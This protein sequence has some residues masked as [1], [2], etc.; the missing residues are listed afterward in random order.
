MRIIL[1]FVLILFSAC[2]QKQETD[3]QILKGS[4]CEVASSKD[5]LHSLNI[6]DSDYIITINN[7]KTTLTSNTLSPFIKLNKQE[8][9]KAT[10]S[11]ITSRKT[12]YKEVVDALDQMAIN[13]IKKYKIV[14]NDTIR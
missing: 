11:I 9:N 10:F 1:F 7:K 2:A 6:S 3:N 12:S 13:D 5:Y 8:I 4:C 14:T